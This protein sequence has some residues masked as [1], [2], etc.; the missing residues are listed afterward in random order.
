MLDFKQKKFGTCCWDR[1]L[2]EAILELYCNRP[3]QLLTM[4]DLYS[5]V[6]KIEPPHSLRVRIY[7]WDS[8]RSVGPWFNGNR[9]L[10][11]YRD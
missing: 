4:F 5:V 6:D 11:R 9:V 10:N 8:L 7:I 3:D 2:R 1:A